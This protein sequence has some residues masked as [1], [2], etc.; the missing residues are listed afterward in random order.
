M[1]TIASADIT[2]LAEALRR[3]GKESEATT[4][5]V[6][7]ES[8]NYILTEMEVRVPVDSGNL[9]QSLG[10][11]VE[12]DRVLIGPD[13]V[14][15]PYG[16]YVEFGTKPHKITAKNGKALAFKMNGQNVVVRSVNHPGTR[17]QPFVQPAFDAWVESLGEMVAE[18]NVKKLKREA[19]KSA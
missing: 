5:R 7:I 13:A 4:Q 9:R 3:S 6:L 11:K 2:Q 12:G 18:A 1:T 16:V 14:Q 15:A 10:I 19:E 8:A 17:A